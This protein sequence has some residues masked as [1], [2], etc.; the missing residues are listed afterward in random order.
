MNRKIVFQVIIN[1][2]KYIRCCGSDVHWIAHFLT[3]RCCYGMHTTCAQCKILYKAFTYLYHNV[4]MNYLFRGD[5]GGKKRFLF[6]QCIMPDVSLR[7]LCHN[8]GIYS[9]R[10]HVCFNMYDIFSIFK[11]IKLS[12]YMVLNYLS[13]N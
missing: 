10:M 2:V 1:V 9:L 8:C 5:V 11:L 12:Q 3:W 4:Q 7:W 13:W 6:V